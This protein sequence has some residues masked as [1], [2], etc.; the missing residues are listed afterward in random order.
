MLARQ[1]LRHLQLRIPLKEQ[2]SRRQ[3]VINV[4]TPPGS[5]GPNNIESNHLQQRQQSE[6]KKE[7]RDKLELMQNLQTEVLQMI[8]GQEEIGSNGLK[9]TEYDS[10]AGLDGSSTNDDAMKKL[11]EEHANLLRRVLLISARRKSLPLSALSSKT[12]NRGDFVKELNMSASI[13]PAGPSFSLLDDKELSYVY[14]KELS[15]SPR[16]T[17]INLVECDDIGKWSNNASSCGRRSRNLSKESPNMHNNIPA[18]D[19]SAQLHVD[20]FSD[21]TIESKTSTAGQNNELSHSKGM[22]RD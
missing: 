16:S 7:L 17:Q 6:D 20:V 14:D 13:I 21:D 12:P 3:P 18:G 10:I 22:L 11:L 4:P 1:L 19:T 9:C 15:S 5:P 8:E 2:L